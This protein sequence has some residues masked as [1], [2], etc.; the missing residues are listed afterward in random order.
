M[1]GGRESSGRHCQ[2]ARSHPR[3]TG[4][5]PAE[6]RRPFR[7]VVG[8]GVV[9]LAVLQ[10]CRSDRLLLIV[11]QL[12]TRRRWDGAGSGPW[13]ERRAIPVPPSTAGPIPPPGTVS[14]ARC[15]PPQHPQH[16]QRGQ[17]PGQ[18]ASRRSRG[19]HHE[20]VQ[21]DQ[22]AP[23]PSDQRPTGTSSS[24]AT[25]PTPGSAT[26]STP[27]CSTARRGRPR[28]QRIRAPDRRIRVRDVIPSGRVA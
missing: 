24:C 27:T 26:T 11:R 19:E 15:R 13:R 17:G 3:A 20:P 2:A 25:P 21:V 8:Q 9:E 10:H 28:E 18:A 12:V 14:A 23:S 6:Q 5:R 22:L 16:D 7:V 1:W 4:H